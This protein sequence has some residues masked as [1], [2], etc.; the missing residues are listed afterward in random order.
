[1]S[2]DHLNS[3]YNQNKLLEHTIDANKGKYLASNRR[4]Y[5]T[6][7]DT[8]ILLSHI[9]I[10]NSI[11]II[12]AVVFGIIIILKNDLSRYFKIAIILIMVIYP[13]FIL[14][15]EQLV[16]ATFKFLYALTIGSFFSNSKWQ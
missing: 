15:I 9:N 1:M 16:Y 12:I 5:Y 3:I 11:Y 13:F 2:Q 10:L 6:D 7:L 4:S 8:E 14:S